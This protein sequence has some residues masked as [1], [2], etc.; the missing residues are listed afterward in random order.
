MSMG[1]A[2]FSLSRVVASSSACLYAWMMTVGCIFSSRNW[3]ET[4]RV[5]AARTI[6]LV[7][8]SPTSSS[9]VLAIS[10]MVLAAG[11]CTVISRKMALPS[12]VMTMPPMGSISILSMALGPRH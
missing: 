5:S 3:W 10:I 6:T 1:V 11:C 12:L 2:T 9:C 8:P 7:V 4:P